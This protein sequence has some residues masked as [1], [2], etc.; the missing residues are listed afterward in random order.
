MYMCSSYAMELATRPSRM[1]AALNIERFKSLKCVR[2]LF[3]ERFSIKLLH[4]IN[5]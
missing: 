5:T 1:N 4:K 2:I 3:H